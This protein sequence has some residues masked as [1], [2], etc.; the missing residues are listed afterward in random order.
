M[1]LHDSWPV[2][3]PFWTNYNVKL[4][5]IWCLN[6][7]LACG[8]QDDSLFGA[9]SVTFQHE[10]RQGQPRGFKN[11]SMYCHRPSIIR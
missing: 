6:L 3:E 4:P 9:G 1:L 11:L 5:L 8:L 7:I 10:F 2:V